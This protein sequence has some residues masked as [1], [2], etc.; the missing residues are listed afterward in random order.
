LQPL[1]VGRWSALG[2]R[3]PNPPGTSWQL[4]FDDEFDDTD[5]DPKLGAP[6]MSGS[7]NKNLEN[8]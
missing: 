1:P 5:L 6:E 2:L 4:V 8:R 3:E 7:V